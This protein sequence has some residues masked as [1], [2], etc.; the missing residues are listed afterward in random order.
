MVDEKVQIFFTILS[1]E[2]VLPVFCDCR[3]KMSESKM[4]LRVLISSFL[5]SVALVTG[6]S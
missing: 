1:K 2:V 6:K 4:S 5:I 3:K